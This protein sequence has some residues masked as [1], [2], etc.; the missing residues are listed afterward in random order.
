V[1]LLAATSIWFNWQ[2]LGA[3]FFLITLLGGILA[4]VVLIIRRIYKNHPIKPSLLWIAEDAGLPYGVAIG[5][6]SLVLVPKISV[7]I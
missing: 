6:S 2:D 4:L 1:K 7:L 3:Y 5:I